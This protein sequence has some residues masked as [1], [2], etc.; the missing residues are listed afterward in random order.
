[1]NKLDSSVQNNNILYLGESSNFTAS[2]NDSCKK[3]ISEL[4]SD[5]SSTYKILTISKGALHAGNFK[6]FIKRLK[7]NSTIKT[8]IVTVNLRSF[9]INWIQS[10]LETNLSRANILYSN[11]L[12]I[13]KK[14]LLSF[15]GYDNVELF[16]RKEIIKSHYKNDKFKLDNQK[17]ET[18]REWDA[19][20]FNKGVLDENGNKNQEKTNIACHFIKNYAFT[21][22]ED[23]P[24][25]NDLDEIVSF[26]ND[27][28]INLIFNLLPENY[29]KANEL[30]GKDL[31]I[32]MANN[33]AFLKKRY[34]KST[35]FIDNFKL[36]KDSCFI[37]KSW[38]TEHYIYFGRK[39]V[40][41]NINE[42]LKT[43]K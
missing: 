27:K 24:R 3:S 1:M 32:L 2:E 43:L 16:K 42:K 25:I 15:K 7:D 6:L 4:V 38:P 26:C 40:A 31:E 19:D 10:D 39:K 30:C 12:P 28:K 33:A 34:E 36:L 21:L 11:H 37:D 8:I 9:G 20:M 5:N 35:L 29:E 14:F 22:T 23:N 17:Y 18:V 13:I 41:D